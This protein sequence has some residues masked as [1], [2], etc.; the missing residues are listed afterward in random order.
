MSLLEK[1]RVTQAFLESK[2]IEKPEFGLILGSGLGELAEEVEDAVVID[3]AD[4]PTGDNQRLSVMLENL[5]ME[6][7]LD[8]RF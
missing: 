4:I 6:P 3:Y 2:G 5:F 1:I 7:C 8:V